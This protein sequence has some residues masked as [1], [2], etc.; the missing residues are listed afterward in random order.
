MGEQLKPDGAA[1]HMGENHRLILRDAADTRQVYCTSC[2]RLVLTYSKGEER[3]GRLTVQRRQGSV[4]LRCTRCS[5]RFG[6]GSR[7]RHCGGDASNWAFVIDAAPARAG[8][9]RRQIAR[10]GFATEQRAREAMARIR[11]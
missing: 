5:R 4:Y 3:E 9:R 1:K 11:E 6:N 7:C 10:S 8:A 2:D